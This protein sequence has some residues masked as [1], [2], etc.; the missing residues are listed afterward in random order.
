MMQ[1]LLFILGDLT[2]AGSDPAGRIARLAQELAPLPGRMGLPQTGDRVVID[3][4]L[5]SRSAA[6]PV[7]GQGEL[8]KCE[9]N[10]SSGWKL[11]KNVPVPQQAL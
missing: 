7:G 2:Y 4:R 1:R 9:R 6:S 8:A 10:Q 5:P 11:R 3:G